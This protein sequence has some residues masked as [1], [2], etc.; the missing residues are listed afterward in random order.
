MLFLC[1]IIVFSV[2]FAYFICEAVCVLP[3]M[4]QVSVY[5]NIKNQFQDYNT[6]YCCCHLMFIAL[7]LYNYNNCF[8]ITLILV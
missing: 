4:D 5:E 6:V 7:H 3:F 2:P 1:F 8:C